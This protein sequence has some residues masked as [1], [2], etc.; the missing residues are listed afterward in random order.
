MDKV[1]CLDEYQVLAM[2]TLKDI[3]DKEKQLEY[4]ILSLCGEAGE[5]AN[6]FKKK[7]YHNK[8]NIN[9]ESYVEEASDALWYI[10]CIADA[11]NMNLSEFAT[12]NIKKL[13]K[14]FPDTEYIEKYY[15]IESQEE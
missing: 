12:F 14:R 6:R 5:L 4:A 3:G 9:I 8:T 2:R 10:A 13:E 1:I 7:R 15:N 11:L